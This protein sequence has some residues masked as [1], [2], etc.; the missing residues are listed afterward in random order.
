MNAGRTEV[1]TIRLRGPVRDFA[2]AAARLQSRRVDLGLDGRERVVEASGRLPG[3]ARVKVDQLREVPECAVE[4]SAPK[5][6]N[7]SNVVPLPLAEAIAVAR[8]V[9]GQVD[10]LV[11][12]TVP[13]EAM[14]VQRIDLDRDF[15]DVDNIG[16]LLSALSR[17]PAPN[18]PATRYFPDP[19]RGNAAT[20]TR[21]SPARWQSTLYS[22]EGEALSRLRSA[23]TDE[24]K[25]A[26]TVDVQ[27]AQRRLRFELRSRTE[28]LG[29][30]G[31][32]LVGDLD[33]DALA[34]MRRY[35]FDRV[36]YGLEVTGM[37]VAVA[38]V[39]EAE[40]DVSV[41]RRLALIGWLSAQA[42]GMAPDLSTRTGFRYK[43]LAQEIGV[44]PADLLEVAATSSV[45]L[46][47]DAARMVAA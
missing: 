20:L 22:K 35:Y 36:G 14:R 29:D 24:Q 3:G 47:F 1:D 7:G 42:Y 18:N 16:P 10:E 41:N 30:R 23:R 21:G 4:F 38:R 31:L 27:K 19:S 5:V 43:S 8:E 9:V 39:M 40:T 46:D 25:A 34:G 17:L 45:R 32:R 12:F 33:D 2:A 13:F 28:V 26:A 44:A 15:E 37:Q 6:A 11:G